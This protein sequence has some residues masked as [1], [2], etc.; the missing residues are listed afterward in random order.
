MDNGSIIY[1]HIFLKKD[2]KFQIY[3]KIIIN[4]SQICENFTFHAKNKKSTQKSSILEYNY[5][6]KTKN[7][8]CS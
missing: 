2:N 7:I 3:L 4:N 8:C 1:F 5:V 6:L